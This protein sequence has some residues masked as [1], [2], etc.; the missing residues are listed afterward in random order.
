M[1]NHEPSLR[2]VAITDSS[3]PLSRI[4]TRV[5]AIIGQLK[6]GKHGSIA[7]GMGGGGYASCTTGLVHSADP[8]ISTSIHFSKYARTCKITSF[9]SII[10]GFSR[11]RIAVN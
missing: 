10:Y 11:N 2:F 6:L 4:L 3:H 5:R 7:D 9:I 8:I 1:T